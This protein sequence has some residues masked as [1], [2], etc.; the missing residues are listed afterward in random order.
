[1]FRRIALLKAFGSAHLAT[2]R[3]KLMETCAELTAGELPKAVTL[4]L[5]KQYPGAAVGRVLETIAIADGHRRSFTVT[6]KTADNKSLEAVLNSN[7]SVLKEEPVK[8]DAKK[9]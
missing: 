5:Q 6:L 9:K 4:S 3:G 1:M 2:S 8:G 7:G